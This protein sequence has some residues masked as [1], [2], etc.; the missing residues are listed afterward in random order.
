[1]RDVI[2]RKNTA[3]LSDE[4]VIPEYPNHSVGRLD[5]HDVFSYEAAP[6]NLGGMPFGATATRANERIKE[7]PIVQSCKNAFKLCDDGRLLNR[8]S[9]SGKIGSSHGKLIPS[10][11]LGVVDGCAPAAPSAFTTSVLWFRR[12]GNSL[13]RIFVINILA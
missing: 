13:S 6:Q 12:I 9:W 1:M 10:S 5:A 7:R 4:R 11:W 8:R 2:R 3:G